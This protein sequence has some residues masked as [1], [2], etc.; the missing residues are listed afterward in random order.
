MVV[1]RALENHNPSNWSK[2]NASDLMISDPITLDKHTLA[3]EALTLMEQNSKNKTISN[4]PIV[5][6]ANG[7]K[8][9]LGILRLH[10]LIKEGI[11]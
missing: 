6:I 5:K 1:L 11:K 10:D 4:I 3:S 7:C 2:L 8:K 9:V